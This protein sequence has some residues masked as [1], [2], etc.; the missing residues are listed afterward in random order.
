MAPS[1]SPRAAGRQSRHQP[2]HLSR[3]R[4]ARPPTESSPTIGYNGTAPGPIL[5]MK[6]GKP[7]TVEVINATDT[8]ELVHWHGF[9]I[10]SDVRRRRR[11]GHTLRPAPN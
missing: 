5:R 6:A 1:Q 4:R 9:Q 7:V 3:Y 10:P 8:P 11:A 2:A